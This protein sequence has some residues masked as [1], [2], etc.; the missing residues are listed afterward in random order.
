MDIYS[1]LDKAFG[2]L[3]YFLLNSWEVSGCVHVLYMYMYV[4]ANMYMYM[5]MH[6]FLMP[7]LPFSHMVSKSR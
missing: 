5:Y 2:Q 3:N 4:L 6:P 1:K 7:T